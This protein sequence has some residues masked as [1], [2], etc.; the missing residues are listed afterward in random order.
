MKIYVDM[1]GVLADA[2]LGMKLWSD[3]YGISVDELFKKKFYHIPGFYK[4]LPPV[5]GA[6]DAFKKLYLKYGNE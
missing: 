5:D 2:G 4:D 1:D 3:R 6:I